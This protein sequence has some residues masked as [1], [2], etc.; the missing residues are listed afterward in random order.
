MPDASR[1]PAGA[2]AAG[3]PPDVFADFTFTPVLP[4]ND[5]VALAVGDGIAIVRMARPDRMNALDTALSQA[6]NAAFGRVEHDP[7]IRAV[8]VTGGPVFMA[9]GDVKSFAAHATTAPETRRAEFVGMF[10][11][12]HGTIHSLRRMGKPVIAAVN[13]SAAGYGLSLMLACDLVICAEDAVLTAAYCLIGTSPDGG[14]SYH[15]PRAVGT[16][17]A[18]ELVL[19]GDRFSAAE[20]ER[21]GMVNQVLPAAEVEGAVLALARRLAKGPPLALAR[22]K[23]LLN[24]SSEGGLDAQLNAEQQCFVDSALTRDFAEGVT[25][26]VQK[27]KADF[28]GT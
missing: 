21:W 19:T 25:A 10:A 8:I 16:K 11:S 28:N 22:S 18:M 20:A 17:K 4:G 2:P 6:L 1:P 15:L 7:A 9:G 5:R 27:R 12:A 14:M 26:F 3:Q 24:R 23:A 13:G